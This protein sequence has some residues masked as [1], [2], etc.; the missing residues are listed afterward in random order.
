MVVS[1][2]NMGPQPVTIEAVSMLSRQQQ[3]DHAQG[4]SVFPLIPA[5]RC[6]C[7]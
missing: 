3:A 4:L 7:P 1:I 2:S 6:G 5:G